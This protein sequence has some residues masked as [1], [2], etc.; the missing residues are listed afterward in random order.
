MAKLKYSLLT[1]RSEDNLENPPSIVLVP[2]IELRS[3]GLVVGRCLYP[4]SHLASL[5]EV[6]Y[7]RSYTILIQNMEESAVF[8]T[9][10]HHLTL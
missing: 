5:I 8:L 7:I 6:L 2:E 4:L 3:S 1:W 10:F 9:F